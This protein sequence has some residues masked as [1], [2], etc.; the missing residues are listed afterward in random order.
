MRNVGRYDVREVLGEL[1]ADPGW[2]ALWWQGEP[3]IATLRDATNLTGAM[4]GILDLNADGGDAPGGT[5][6]PHEGLDPA[7]RADAW[8]RR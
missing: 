5:P 2:E 3:T 8:R 4:T 7:L 6:V 1:S